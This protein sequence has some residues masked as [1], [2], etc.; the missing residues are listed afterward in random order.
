MKILLPQI[1]HFISFQN[2]LGMEA[3][4]NEAIQAVKTRLRDLEAPLPTYLLSRSVAGTTHTDII[5]G[6]KT[7]ST[8]KIDGK[9][10]H[11]F[12]ERN[13]D[14][15][16]WLKKWIHL[17][18]VPL[19]TFNCQ[20]IK[21]SDGTIPDAWHHQMVYGVSDAGIHLTNPYQILSDKLCM[22]QLCS[23]SELLI[24]RNDV[25]TRWETN[26]DFAPLIEGRWKD[27]NVVEQVEKVIK[28]EMFKMIYG[29]EINYEGLET[30][31]VIIP[32]AYKSG[33]TLFAKTNSVAYNKLQNADDL[34]LK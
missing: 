12:P 5:N 20:K 34:P 16:L 13:V 6:V 23:K 8:N 28:E 9:F 27:L 4:V 17:G 21:N 30:T 7:L 32:A 15:S 31:H 11:F 24:H 29:R 2:A 3:D 18:A 33:V 19:V 10:F 1:H 14:L 25:I 22:T 26:M